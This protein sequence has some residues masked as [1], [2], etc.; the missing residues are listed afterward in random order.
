MLIV[1]PR[2]SSFETA[3]R[4]S[5]ALL[6]GA[7]ARDTPAAGAWLL[8]DEP[9]IVLGA[10]Q[11]AGRVL[12]EVPTPGWSVLRRAT[13][14]TA[15]A[16]RGGL[17]V[18]LALPA[19]D[20][21]FRDATARTVLNRNLR[22]YLAGLAHAGVPCAYL[23]R[24]WIAW[25]RRPL[26]VVGLEMSSSGALLLELFFSGREGLALPRELLTDEER[27][28]D[29]QRGRAAASLGEA[30]G[31]ADL[32]GFARAVLEGMAERVDGDV[33]DVDIV[34]AEL[35]TAV[36]DR[37]SP[38]PRGA[39][40]LAPRE[41]PIGWLDA[42]RTPAG[43]WVGGDMLAPTVG[44]GL[45]PQRVDLPMEGASWSDVQRSRDAAR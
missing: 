21:V 7:S 15:V 10:L 38:L 3:L 40:L 35:R 11:V 34:P 33:T 41:I 9:T 24:E 28:V 31:S 26:A 44:L 18:S 27:S 19:I 29:R 12:T 2:T 16:L 32:A 42:A 4:S 8:P 20:A 37:E 45:L 1:R 6:G 39:T 13:T 17:L 43:V 25:R 23:G 14:G 5:A 22:L 30:L 36:L